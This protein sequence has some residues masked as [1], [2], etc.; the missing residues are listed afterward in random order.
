MKNEQAYQQMKREKAQEI[1][2]LLDLFDGKITLSELLETDIPL[3]H[4]LR[5]AKIQ[6]NSQR[7]QE[8][9]RAS[10]KEKIN[11]QL[12]NPDDIAEAINKKGNSV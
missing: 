8:Q 5:D 12:T 10:G 7:Q 4:Q 3:I 6:L 9:I 2:I 11:A 1:I